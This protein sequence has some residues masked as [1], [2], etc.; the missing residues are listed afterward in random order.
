MTPSTSLPHVARLL[1]MIFLIAGL[2]LLGW[3]PLLRAADQDN[4]RRHSL[5]HRPATG[6]LPETRS[7]HGT[8]VTSADTQPSQILDT[9]AQTHAPSPSTPTPSSLQHKLTKR[10]RPATVAPVPSP[11]TAQSRITK[12]K[13]DGTGTSLQAN[14]S[15]GSPVVGQGTTLTPSSPFQGLA[16]TTVAPATSTARPPSSSLAGASASNSSSLAGTSSGPRTTPSRTGSRTALNLL[17]NPAIA[18][19]LQPPAPTVTSPPS[20][21]PT[22]TPPPSTS[23]PSTTPRPTPPPSAPPPTTGSATLTWSSNGEPDLAG[24]KVY[25][26]TQ[27]GLYTVSGSP[28]PVGRVASYTV[29]NLPRGYTYFFAISAYDSVGNESPLSVEVSKSIY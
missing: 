28:F 6:T 9:T 24:Y 29:M 1:F 16:S 12:P 22:S 25:V 7:T 19:L 15:A 13:T 8:I 18:G 21:P 2:G 27:S 10:P 14:T 26:G 20:Q 5:I 17:Q 3:P 23:P 4:E 11:S